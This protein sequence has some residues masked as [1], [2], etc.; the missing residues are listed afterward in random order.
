MQIID[1]TN[2][3][4]YLYYSTILSIHILN[5]F[6]ESSLLTYIVGALT[7]PVLLFSF[8]GAALLFKILG[9][10]FLA[11]GLFLFLQTGLSLTD[12]LTFFTTNL[13]LIALLT[14]LPWMNIVVRAGRF[15]RRINTLMKANVTNMGSLYV[16]STITTYTLLSFINLSALNLTQGVLKENL[17]NTSKKFRDT[18]ISQT[19]LRAFSMALVWSPMEI[20]VA[21]SVDATG[22]SY[23]TMLPWLL[24]FSAIMM[25]IESLRGKRAYS[26]LDYTPP[27]E[28]ARSLS[29]KNIMISVF[30]LLIALTLFLI[31]I[32]GIGNLFQLNFIYT[33]TLVIFPFACAWA[34]LM[35]RWRSFLAIGLKTWRVRTNTMQNFFVLFVTLSFFSNSLNETPVLQMIQHP[36]MIVSDYPLLILVFMQLTYL[37]MSMFGIH[38]IAT[39]GVLMEVV[40]PLYS[41]MNPLSIGIVFITGALATACVGTYGVTVTLT[42][43]N[44][45]QNP[46]RITLTNLPFALLYGSVG[47]LL[48]FLLL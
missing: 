19:T 34:F 7:I 37:I 16:R 1:T 15:D 17:K 22:V 32:V 27:Y 36:F 3:H 14:V 38:P 23:L 21:I 39:I 44:T 31:L 29:M 11:A 42:S 18:F 4:L 45:Q 25:T 28:Q 24:L 30:Q 20:L 47:T 43:M 35:K 41:L 33:V 6:I 13:G 12:A 26:S 10:I 9:T 40:T 8:L 2:R 48:A 5:I 46:Y